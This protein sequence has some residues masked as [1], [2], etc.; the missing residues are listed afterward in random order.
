MSGAGPAPGRAGWGASTRAL[1]DAIDAHIRS[2]GVAHLHPSRPT[3]QRDLLGG[4]EMIA[5]QDAKGAFLWGA[6]GCWSELPHVYARYGTD[7]T[8]ALLARLRD[9]YAA[10]GAVVTDCGMQAIAL[11]ADAV[12]GPGAH[13]VMTRQVYNK[14]RTLL[15]WQTERLGGRLT[16]V[17]DG[18]LGAVAAA[19]EPSTCL[20]FVESFTNPL[21][22]A[23]DIPGL[24]AVVA[25]AQARA[26]GV[27]LAVDDTLLTPFGPRESLLHLGADVVV[28]AGTKALGGEDTALWGYLVARDSGLLNQ[29]MDLQA[30]R[31]G[32]MDGERAGGVAAGLDAARERWSRRCASASAIAAFLDAHPAVESVW[33]PG[34]P[35]HPDAEVIARDV[36]AHGSLVAFRWAGADEDAH[37]HLADVLAMTEVW[38][39]ALSF[40]GLC[41]KVNHH[42]TVSEYH[43]PPPVRRKLG[44]DR[45]IRLAVGVED[46]ADLIAALAWAIDAAPRVS[47]EEVAGWQRRRRA[48]LG[49]PG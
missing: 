3:V 29:V 32:V 48:E 31:G 27:R 42:T 7:G 18:D 16:E 12:I 21:G 39:Y 25:D 28:G 17:E 36:V 13:V 46:A 5:W 10:P 4:A 22:R 11:L 33:H 6:E 9:L 14:T 2:S 45:L 38:R 41:S 24:A 49:L 40:D 19:I 35:G 8:R 1:H 43:T 15:R 23:Q 20:V 30:M 26:P 44:L 37:R 47:P 34:Q